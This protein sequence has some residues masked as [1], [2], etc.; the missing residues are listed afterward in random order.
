M[1]SVGQHLLRA[2]ATDPKPV[3]QPGI[4]RACDDAVLDLGSSPIATSTDTAAF[5][6]AAST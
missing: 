3:Q 2:P 6:G 4:R 5:N 1:L